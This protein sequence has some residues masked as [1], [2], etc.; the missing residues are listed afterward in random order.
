M[1]SLR[2]HERETRA[3]R[4][5]SYIAR[6]DVG[7][8]AKRNLPPHPGKLRPGRVVRVDHRDPVI[9]EIIDEASLGGEIGIERLVI[10][11]MIARQIGEDRRAKLQAV[12]TTLIEAMRGNLHRDQL[13]ECRLQV[14]RPRRRQ[15]A[16]LTFDRCACWIE[17]AQRPDRPHRPQ[18]AQHMPGENDRGRLAV[19]PRHS[20]HL[21]PCRRPAVPRLGGDGGGP[22][23]VAHDDLRNRDGLADFD[24]RRRRAACRRIGD[25]VV[26]VEHRPADGAEQHA[27]LEPPRVR[28]ETGDR[29]AGTDARVRRIDQDAGA[30]ERVYDLLQRSAH[31]RDSG[32]GSANTVTV[33]PAVAC[34]PAAGHV[35]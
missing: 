33:A 1:A 4:V 28:G 23:A 6:G 18:R 21:Q 14:D 15:V 11:E 9:S 27:T 10:I 12:D 2:R 31:G 25:E 29:G 34:S 20:D 5:H 8:L 30:R 17:R 32:R 7:P 13:G 24:Q 35:W 3:L 26:A 22:P 19:R 16:R